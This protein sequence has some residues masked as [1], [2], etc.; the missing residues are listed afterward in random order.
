[1]TAIERENPALQ[2]ILPRDYGR[3]TMDQQRLEKVIGLIGNIRAGGADA[4]ATDVLGRVYEYFL[5]HFAMTEGRKGGEF[6][7][8]RS[9]VQLLVEMT[10]PYRGRVYDP[11]CGSAGMFTQSVRFIEAHATGGGTGISIYG[12][13]SNQTTWRLA[14]IN[15]A[16]RGIQGRVEC[17]DSLLNDLHPNLRADCILSNPP[18]NMKEWRREQLLDDR[19]WKHGLPPAGNAN[20][21]WVQHF[22]HHLAPRGIAGFVLANGSTSSNQAGEKEIRKNIT[23]AGLVDCITA[24]PSQLFRSTQIPACL[25][26]LRRDRGERKG[27]T[28]FIDARKLG[29]LTDRTHRD[30]SE[31]DIARIA[32]VYHAWRDG[33]GYAD[34]PGFCRSAALEEIRKQDHALTPGRYTGAEPRAVDGEAFPEKM[35]RLT[36]QWR[37]EQEEAR[38]LD[39]E[40]A[41]NL[42]ALGFGQP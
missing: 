8:P 10:Q 11:C 33:D 25:W 37:K 15:L 32:G 36:R 2:D 24:L 39:E 27:Q 19:R 3:N 7:T 35:A 41:R 29:H 5:E 21:A 9:V 28:L 16:I 18:F 17:G 30:L 22:L 20:F 13:E 14:R 40:I 42:E 23:Q 12:Q 6:Y 31:A 4:Q 26:F 1:M 38:I 34:I